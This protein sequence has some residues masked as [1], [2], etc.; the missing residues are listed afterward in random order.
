MSVCKV[1][2]FCS[3]NVPMICP[4]TGRDYNQEQSAYAP[5]Q[6]FS[7]LVKA[8]NFV[9]RYTKVPL[10]WEEISDDCWCVRLDEFGAN[11]FVEEG[12]N[13]DLGPDDQ[14][15]ELPF[16]FAERGNRGD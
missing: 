9:Q 1:L 5:Y 13:F 15:P 6:Y 3:R 14:K 16:E 12:S 2:I 11:I 4:A 10:E 7:T 8:Q